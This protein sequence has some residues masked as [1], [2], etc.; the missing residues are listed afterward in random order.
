MDELK[1]LI[2]EVAAPFAAMVVGYAAL[3]VAYSQGWGTFV[4]EEAQLVS[5]LMAPTLVGV[6]AY[7]KANKG[8]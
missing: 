8:T 3:L 6:L 2:K 7:R 5:W 1:V 4:P